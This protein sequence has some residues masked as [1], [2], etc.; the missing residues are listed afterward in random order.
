MANFKEML[1]KVKPATCASVF[2]GRFDAI[3]TVIPFNPNWA[4]GTGYFD[5]AVRGKNCVHLPPG[6][7]AKSIAKDGRKMIF[8][9]TRFGVVVMFQR[10][11]D[12]ADFFVHNAPTDIDHLGLY[13][14]SGQRRLEDVRRIVGDDDMGVDNLGHLIE[15]IFKLDARL[16]AEK[17]DQAEE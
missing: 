13:N 16:Q 9:G 10:Y 7:C 5:N 15:K 14:T 3:E 12:N 8:V 6:V 11:T 2:F 1:T 17:L 4:N